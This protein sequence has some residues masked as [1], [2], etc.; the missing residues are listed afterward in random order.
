MATNHQNQSLHHLKRNSP[1]KSNSPRIHPRR[2][3]GDRKDFRI[4]KYHRPT[5]EDKRFEYR[6]TNAKMKQY[7]APSTSYE[8]FLEGLRPKA[9]TAPDELSDEHELNFPSISSVKARCACGTSERLFLPSY[10]F[11]YK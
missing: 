11:R 4:Q 3:S 6:R 10:R 7:N 5:L 8:D 1:R 9:I 2:R